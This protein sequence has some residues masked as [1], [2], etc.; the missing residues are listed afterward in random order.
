MDRLQGD[1]SKRPANTKSDQH[2]KQASNDERCRKRLKCAVT[3]CQWTAG[4]RKR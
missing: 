3:F 1:A 2:D 4:V